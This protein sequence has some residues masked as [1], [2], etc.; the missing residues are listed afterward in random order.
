[1]ELG[2]MSDSN[3]LLVYL[4]KIP[5]HFR[6]EA[7]WDNWPTYPGTMFHAW[8]GN[9]SLFSDNSPPWKKGQQL[10]MGPES[11]TTVAH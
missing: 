2:L 5:G 9:F 1:M 8:M 11:P 10:L 6:D 7:S 4:K 3:P